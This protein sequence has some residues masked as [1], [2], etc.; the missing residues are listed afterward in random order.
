[1]LCWLNVEDDDSFPSDKLT[2]TQLKE[3]LIKTIEILSAIMAAAKL[4]MSD[5]VSPLV[6][7]EPQLQP[8]F[9]CCESR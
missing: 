8:L 3:Q 5:R 9:A 2:K 1:M 6:A 4:N 7:K